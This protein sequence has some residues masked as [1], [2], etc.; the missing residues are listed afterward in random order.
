MN[1]V[2]KYLLLNGVLWASA[3]LA[4]ALVGAPTV[5]TLIVLPTLGATAFLLAPR[6]SGS[7]GGGKVCL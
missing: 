5:L 2:K 1:P 4:A 7:D 3:I 6:R